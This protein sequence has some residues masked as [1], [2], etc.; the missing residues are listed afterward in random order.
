[1]KRSFLAFFV[2]LLLIVTAGPASARDDK[3]EKEKALDAPPTGISATAATLAAV[4]KQHES[5]IGRHPGLQESRRE[6]WSRNDLGFAGSETLFR[7]GLDYVS[8][9]QHG[10]FGEEYGQF[11]G[12]RWHKVP[13]G[14]VYLMT[15]TDDESFAMFRVVEDAADPKNDAKLLGEIALPKPAYVV[16]VRLSGAKHPEW[17]LYDKESGLIVRTEA[18][19]AGRRLVAYYEDY[20]TTNGYTEPW[21]VRDSVAELGLEDDFMRTA[22]TLGEPVEAG[23]FAAP[24]GAFNPGVFDKPGIV[25]GR[26]TNETVVV[27]LTVNGRGLDFELSTGAPVSIIDRDVA[28]EL[29]LPTFGQT[30]QTK[31]GAHV[32]YDTEIPEARVGESVVLHHVALRAVSF[33]YMADYGTKIVGLLGTDFLQSGVFKIDFVNGRTEVLMENALTDDLLKGAYI[34]PLTIDDGLPFTSGSIGGHDASNMLIDCRFPVSFIMA[35]FTDQHPD[36]VPD[37]AGKSRRKAVVPFADSA[38]YGRE[39]AVWL[40]EVPDFRFSTAHFVKLPVVATNDDSPY[41]HDVDAIVGFDMLWY[42]DM[43]LDYANHRMFL[44]PNAHFSQRFKVMPKT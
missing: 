37:S 18:S 15:T 38:T 26:V 5:A 32:G 40:S 36:A 17:I 33:N 24:A 21:H 16:E 9:I 22:L 41:D 2:G 8:H 43:Y 20:R 10:P 31:T 34:V 23:I 14:N 44:K 7:R 29:N 42:F 13:N 6:V 3:A 30:I 11:E 35:P 1:M 12:R 25:A 28:R 4:L 27:R 19:V 39:L